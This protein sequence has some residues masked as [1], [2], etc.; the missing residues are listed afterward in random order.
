MEVR[1]NRVV[2]RQRKQ[3]TNTQGTAFVGFKS[4][5]RRDLVFP[6]K[7]AFFKDVVKAAKKERHKKQHGIKAFLPQCPEV[8]RIRVKKDDFHIEEYKQDGYQKIFDSGG[9]PGI[10]HRRNT[11]FK[12]SQLVVGNALGTQQVRQKQGEH[13]K[14]YAHKQLQGNGQVV[15]RRAVCSI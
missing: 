3:L 2:R 5:Q 9:L 14:A 15:I 4:R 13:H 6:V 11:A 10:A 12:R 8:Y 7:R 1:C